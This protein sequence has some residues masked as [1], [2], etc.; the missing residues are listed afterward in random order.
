MNESNLVNV[1][2]A[3]ILKAGNASGFTLFRGRTTVVLA[4]SLPVAYLSLA[5]GVS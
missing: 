2:V 4:A 1:I 5:R 3:G